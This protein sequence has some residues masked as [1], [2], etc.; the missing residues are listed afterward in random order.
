MYDDEYLLDHIIDR[1]VDHA[2]ATYGSPHERKIG[3]VNRRERP[4]HKSVTGRDRD[5]LARQRIHI[6]HYG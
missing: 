4:F 6:R 2:E 1:T 3:S 5:R